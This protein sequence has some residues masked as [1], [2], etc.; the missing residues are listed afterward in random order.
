MKPIRRLPRYLL[1]FILWMG[2]L[3]PAISLALGPVDPLVG[4]CRSPDGESPRAM[5]GWFEH[6][7]SCGALDQA[8]G[9]PSSPV[10]LLPPPGLRPVLV[11]PAAATPSQAQPRLRPPARAPPQAA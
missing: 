9:A 7:A 4:V 8:L 5:A 2:L 11:A 10:L 3:A 1:V 6:C